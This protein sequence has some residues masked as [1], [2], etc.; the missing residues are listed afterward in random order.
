VSARLLSVPA[1]TTVLGLVSIAAAGFAESVPEMS[2]DGLRRVADS[3]VQVAYLKPGEDLHEYDKL[4]ILDCF[5]AFKKNWKRHHSGVSNR[6]IERIKQALAEEFRK[7]FVEELQDRGGYP[8]VEEA[9]ADVLIVRPAI[10]D[11]DVVA[12]DTM[13]AG[14]AESFTTSAGS[15]TLVIELHDSVSGALLAR[16][17]D[18]EA[19]NHPGGIEWTTRSSNLS[20][21]RVILRRWASLLRE[22]L[23][24][25][26]EQKA[27]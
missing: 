6:D 4:Q 24:S 5:V 17:I 13:T 26:R 7:V 9:G 3:K 27:D 20:D 11:L 18:R 16:A 25:V 23:D 12:P 14:R 8:I 22:R 1:L 19:A 15:M 2:H 21:A 10:I